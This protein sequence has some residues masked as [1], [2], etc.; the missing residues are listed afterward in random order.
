MPSEIRA[1]L[2]EMRAIRRA[3]FAELAD[4]PDARMDA[5][6]VWSRGPADVRFLFLHIAE[7]EDD[8]RL[9]IAGLLPEMGARQTGAQRILGNAEATRGE[10]NGALVGLTDDDLDLSPPGEW[11]LRAVLAHILSVERSYLVNVRHALALH[12]AGRPF[13]RAPESAF[14][15]ESDLAG[16]GLA[17]IVA[18]LDEAREQTL[19]EL[20]GVPDADLSAPTRWDGRDVDINFRLLRFA[21]HEREHTMHVLKWRE[22]VGR[23]PTEAQRLLA[24]AWRARGAQHAQLVG[25]PDAILDA[26]AGGDRVTVRALLDHVVGS[27]AYLKRQVEAAG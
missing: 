12:R 17:E 18:R 16:L 14:A 22:Q 2:A 21:D 1:V 19:E 27:E 15:P 3:R 9:Q 25:Q 10:L 13:E 11:P 5:M 4:V 20:S 24:L 7:H 6:G 23:A 26:D 8:H